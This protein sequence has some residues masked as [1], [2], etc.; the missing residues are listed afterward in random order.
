MIDEV[1]KAHVDVAFSPVPSATSGTVWLLE[2]RIDQ[3]E[4]KRGE[5]RVAG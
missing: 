2:K 3:V 1:D 4:S 5:G